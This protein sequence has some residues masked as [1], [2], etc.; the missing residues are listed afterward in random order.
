MLHLSSVPPFLVEGEGWREE[1][2]EQAFCT[3]SFANFMKAVVEGDF[4]DLA[5]AP[6]S[7]NETIERGLPG[8]ICRFNAA[9]FRA[10]VVAFRQNAKQIC[11]LA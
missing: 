2:M 3:D 1:E 11:L 10:D 9:Y 8:N 5:S 7:I 6:A 4:S